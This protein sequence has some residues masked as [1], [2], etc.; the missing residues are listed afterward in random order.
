MLE[1]CVVAFISTLGAFVFSDV[2][3]NFLRWLTWILGY[4]LEQGDRVLVS[5]V[6]LGIVSHA[7]NPELVSDSEDIYAVKT[8]NPGQSILFKTGIKCQ[9]ND[10]E[11]LYIHIRSSLGIKYNLQL[12]NGTGIIDADYYNNPDNE[13]EILIDITN[14]GNAPYTFRKGD[15]IA[16]GIFHR[17]HT[18]DTED[19]D[20]LPERVGGVGST[21]K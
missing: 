9:M 16:Q 1:F 5:G 2:I 15:R 14:R 10:D 8:L 21:G 6:G 12:T 4:H 18:V 17:Y 3:M 11:V 7:L 20:N 13:G 19:V